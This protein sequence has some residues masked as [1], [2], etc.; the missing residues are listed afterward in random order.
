MSFTVIEIV[1]GDTFKVSPNWEWTMKDGSKATG[2]TVRIANLNAPEK[3]TQDGAKATTALSKIISG[4]TVDLKN[5]VNL[6]YGRVV[7]DVYLNGSNI[8][9]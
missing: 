9:E 6:S 8:L 5:A 3:G 4:K 1:D 2:D 7:C